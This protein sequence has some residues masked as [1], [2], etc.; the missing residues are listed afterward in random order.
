MP[1]FTVH[2]VSTF[3][4]ELSVLWLLG[5][6]EMSIQVLKWL[7]PQSYQ[8]F[9]HYFEHIPL[10]AQLETLRSQLFSVLFSTSLLQKE[11]PSGNSLGSK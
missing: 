7:S 11:G 6:F 8:S 5:W 1:N 10:Q 9:S 3:S 4:L 2:H